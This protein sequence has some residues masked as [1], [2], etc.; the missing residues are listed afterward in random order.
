ML[1]GTQLLDTL[2][3][4][5]S[6][7]AIGLVAFP[8]TYVLFRSFRDRGWGFSK[9]L[10]LL[11]GSYVVWLLS[12]AH[13]LPN[14][15]WA[16]WLVLALAAVPSGIYV[17][18]RREEFRRLLREEW[19]ALA[20]AELAF[21]FFFVAW[22]AYR[23]HDPAISGTEKPMD[24]LFLNASV[25]AVHAPPQDPWLSGY[26]VA[27]YYFGYWMM[28]ALSQMAAVPTYI[29]Y[30]LSLALI[31]GMSA[32]GMFSLVYS[33][34]RSDGGRKAAAIGGAIVSIVLLLVVGNLIGFWE[35][36]SLYNIGSERFFHW[37]AISGLH[38]HQA[39]DFW[40]PTGF[41]WWWRA[42]RVINH[43]N[44][45]GQGLDYTI[46]EFPF[47]SLLL[48]DLHP[49]LMSIPFVLLVVGLI[50]SV[51]VSPLRWGISWI[52]SRPIHALV[53]ALVI[54][55][56][57]F[58]NTWDIAMS[59]LL[60]GVVVALK[61]YQERDS[62]L[63]RAALRAAP[64]A[65]IIVGFALIAYAPFYF[66]TFSSQ[67]PAGAPINAV[68]YSTRYVQFLTVWGLMLLV[69]APFFFTSVAGV[70]LDITKAVFGR[71]NLVVPMQASER[72]FAREPVVVALL[73]LILPFILWAA[74]YMVFNPNAY[75]TEIAHR[76]L[77]LI[78]LG[79]ATFLGFVACASRARRG[80]WDA[81]LF[82][83]ILISL[84]LY[85]LYG[86]EL[87]YVRDLFGD[88]MNTVFKTYYEVWMLLAAAGGFAIHYWL[89]R[90]ASWTRLGQAVSRTV[91][92][93]V[94][95][96]FVGALYY[97]FAASFSKANGFTSKPTLDGLAFVSEQDPQER[98]AIN[99]LDAH[100]GPNDVVLEAVGSSY[101]D[102][103]RIS[104]STGVPTVI[105]WVEHEHQWRG[106]TAPFDGRAQDV[107]TIYTTTDV[108]LARSL[109][110]KYGVTYVYVG[111]RERS[112]YG[113]AGLGKFQ[114]L[115][116][117][118]FPADGKSG[119][120]VIYRVRG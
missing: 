58:V 67:V 14:V 59:T 83:L 120:V 19:R 34:I 98:A 69:I 53:L 65:I 56:V 68:P 2:R 20:V 92:A 62:G 89:A 43:F 75:A 44:A 41:W 88:R 110:K 36:A 29:S 118:V 60:F 64:A 21:L 40:H 6:I 61:V 63:V 47:F 25:R 16:Y 26:A 117:R 18:K 103:G 37:L 82:V 96:L 66:G 99:W 27:Y 106:T 48:G 115:G 30:N 12:N 52:R 70:G 78:P 24:F 17:W 95:V 102:Y 4:L 90:R 104:S 32:C 38:A 57:G 9:P 72:G 93:I 80:D 97:P 94:A 87:L 54:G 76:Y 11:L 85:L 77:K 46:E 22:I 55:G 3:W 74:V 51:F 45:A 109:L 23:A 33:L 86:T 114:E 42:S 50:R 113:T 91:L 5:L 28:G 116:T 107:A 39:G 71:T 35:V 81:K 10:G 84:S 101:S 1:P 100:A 7:E 112:K 119:D 49:H 105:G 73:A 13:V 31:A 111:S 15:G 108:S 79:L 8:L